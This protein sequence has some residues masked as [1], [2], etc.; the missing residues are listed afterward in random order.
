MAAALS[1]HT[2]VVKFLILEMHCEPTSRNAN[3]N[4]AVH[5]VVKGHLNVI[6]SDLNCDPN[7]PG[8]Y[9]RTPLHCAAE[10]GHLHIVKYL[11]DEQGCNPSCLDEHKNTPLHCAS[12]EGHLDI[13]KF[14]TVEKH[15]DPMCR[16]SDQDTPLH[17][18]QH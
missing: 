16:D 15:C 7:I 6:N 13:V 17:I 18:A 9:D 14:L 1:G 10:F 4:I 5:L 3:N 2:E 11:T 8:Q 12:M